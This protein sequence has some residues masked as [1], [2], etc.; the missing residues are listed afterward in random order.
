[1]FRRFPDLF[2]KVFKEAGGR[3]MMGNGAPMDN[4]PAFDRNLALS[5]AMDD[6]SLLNDLMEMFFQDL[7]EKLQN[8]EEAV[9][10]YDLS[11]LSKQAHGIKGELHTL[12][13]IHSKNIAYRLEKVQASDDQEACRSM[14]NQLKDSIE[15][16]RKLVFRDTP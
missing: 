3:L 10:A 5:Y 2:L 4:G 11:G 16:A 14:L 12:G 1:M 7:P 8:L 9:R 13:F 15:S 6:E